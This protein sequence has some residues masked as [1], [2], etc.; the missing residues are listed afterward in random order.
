MGNYD[1]L[2]V[3]MDVLWSLEGENSR[4]VL[5]KAVCV[6]DLD[7]N[8]NADFFVGSPRSDRSGYAGEESGEVWLLLNPLHFI[9]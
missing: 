3:N 9:E 8:G 7:N 2:K 5:G 1:T 6:S 4:G